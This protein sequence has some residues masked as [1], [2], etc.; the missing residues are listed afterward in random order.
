MFTK[1][2]VDLVELGALAGQT[3]HFDK[4]RSRVRKLPEFSGSCP[5]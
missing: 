5:V 3:G 4:Y 1:P 2:A